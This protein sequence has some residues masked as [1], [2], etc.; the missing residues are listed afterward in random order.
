MLFKST[1]PLRFWQKVYAD[2]SGCWLWQ[3]A[4]DRK[5]YGQLRIA[6]RLQPAHRL[7]YEALV[8]TIAIGLEP[9]HLCRQPSC[10]RPNHLEAV[11]HS[12]NLRRGIWPNKLKTHCPYGHPYAGDNLIV[13][14]RGRQCRICYRRRHAAHKKRLI[15]QRPPISCYSCG[16]SMPAFGKRRYCSKSCKWRV[17]NAKRRPAR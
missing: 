10:V 15:A 13:A 9:D 16:Q 2:P 14:G 5:G 17:E 6:R 3:G 8:S 4:K 7:S 1:L 12:E 11:T